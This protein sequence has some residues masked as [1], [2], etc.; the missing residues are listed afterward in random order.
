MTVHFP[1]WALAMI[2]LWFTIW[3][4]L[5]P[6]IGV[7]ICSSHWQCPIRVRQQVKDWQENL[8]KT[9]TDP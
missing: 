9:R 2:I 1:M 6:W 5:G 8:A 4:V 3:S 7:K